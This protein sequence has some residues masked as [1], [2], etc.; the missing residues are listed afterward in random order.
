MEMLITLLSY[1]QIE[2]I[3]FF[4]HLNET[5]LYIQS[6]NAKWPLVYYCTLPSFLHMGGIGR[7]HFH[8]VQKA[9]KATAL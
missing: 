1:F 8:T 6:A 7:F 9:T 5:S 4:T 3:A 2:V